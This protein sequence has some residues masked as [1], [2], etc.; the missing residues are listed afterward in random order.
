M[1]D[2][3]FKKKASEIENKIHDQRIEKGFKMTFQD[4]ENIIYSGLKEVARDQ[5]HAS[6]GNVNN[7]YNESEGDRLDFSIVERL[8]INS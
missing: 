4:I 3:Y 8:I 5:R 2:K 6:V 1:N 7:F